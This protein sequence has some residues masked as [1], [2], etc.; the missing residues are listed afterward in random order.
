[1][2]KL[3]KRIPKTKAGQ[4]VIAFLVMSYISLLRITCKV[5]VTN[6][7]VIHDFA[8]SKQP[9]VLTIWHGRLLM[10]PLL[11][12]RGMK[13]RT[14]ISGHS[15][16]KIVKHTAA[17]FGFKTIVGSSSQGGAK[18]FKEMIKSIKQGVSV[19]ITPDGPKG[20]KEKFQ[21]GAAE[22]ARM[23]NAPMLAVSISATPCKFAKSWDNFM[24][25]KPF[26]NIYIH[27]GEPMYIT[28]SADETERQG[29]YIRCEKMLNQLQ[30]D[31]DSEAGAI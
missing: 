4:V 3:I 10:M 13:A 5:H 29:F 12:P 31:A 23:T 16:G 30:H 1:M 15:D 18:A 11:F 8:R 22:V 2:K 28:R 27:Y 24:L 20:P 6:G 21:A 9:V 19:F 17:A 7:N 14:L 25:P 26:S